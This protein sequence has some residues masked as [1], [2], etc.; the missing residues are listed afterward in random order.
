MF[1]VIGAV[2][3]GLQVQVA[4]PPPRVPLPKPAPGAI[5]VSNHGNT[6][7]AGSLNGKVLTVSL[8]VVTGA[9]RPEGDTDPEVPILAFAEAGKGP[10]NP[11]PLIRVRQGTEIHLTITNRTDSSLVINGLRPA[12]STGTDSVHL[13]P[14]SMRELSYRLDTPGTYF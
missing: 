1:V 8:E 5:R 3:L 13:P 4:A 14:Q 7:P 9:W 12:V 6:R 2:A 11:G 10:V